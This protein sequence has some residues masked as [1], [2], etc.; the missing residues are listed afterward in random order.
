MITISMAYSRQQ[1]FKRVRDDML[2]GA[3]QEFMCGEISIKLGHQNYWSKE[4]SKILS[5]FTAFMDEKQVATTFKNRDKAIQEIFSEMYLSYYII[6]K[7]KN[8]ILSY[9]RFQSYFNLVLE[10]DLDT[11]QYFKKM[12]NEFL[13]EFSHLL[14]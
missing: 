8:K 11:E 10:L 7:A 4:V 3:F 1:F 14:P 5:K 9:P 6:T 2:S 13:P 12:I